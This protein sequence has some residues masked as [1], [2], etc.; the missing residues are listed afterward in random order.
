MGLLYRGAVS[1]ESNSQITGRISPRLLDLVA[2]L[3]S[4][5]AGAYCLSRED[6]ADSLRGVAIGRRLGAPCCSS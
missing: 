4:G 2:A 6:V 1:F 5:A 3:A